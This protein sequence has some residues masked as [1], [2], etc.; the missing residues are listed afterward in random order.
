[1]MTRFDVDHHA[2]ESD[3]VYPDS[4]NTIYFARQDNTEAKIEVLYKD[5]TSGDDTM[6]TLDA[7][8]HP[9]FYTYNACTYLDEIPFDGTPGS[10]T[11][12]P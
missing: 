4:F 10:P 1:M 3:E 6:G 11:A 5:G 2:C 7:V 12:S 8:E 9:E